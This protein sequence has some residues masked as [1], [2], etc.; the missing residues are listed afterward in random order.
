MSCFHF[1][2]F[3]LNISPKVSSITSI[4]DPLSREGKNWLQKLDDFGLGKNVLLELVTETVVCKYV[5]TFFF[6]A[7]LTGPRL[8]LLQD[9][10]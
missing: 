5:Y 9:N 10:H 7:E 6:L 4:N 1:S 8:P 2:V 3:L